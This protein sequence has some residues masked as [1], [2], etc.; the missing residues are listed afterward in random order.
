VIR[1]EVPM[2]HRYCMGAVD[3]TLKG[4]PDSTRLLSGI[5][6]L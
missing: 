2:Q 3:C 1:D 5:V 6:V 4:I